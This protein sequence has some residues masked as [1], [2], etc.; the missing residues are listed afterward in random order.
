[1]KVLPVNT[2][3]GYFYNCVGCSGHTP[4]ELGSKINKVLNEAGE[5]NAEVELVDIKYDVSSPKEEFLTF[6]A[7]VILRSKQ[8]IEV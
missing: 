3:T 1:M 4:E 6:S 5:L 2:A 7:Q 8:K